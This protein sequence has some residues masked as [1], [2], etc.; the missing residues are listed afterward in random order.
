MK[1]RMTRGGVKKKEEEDEE[2]SRK[3]TRGVGRGRRR[4][5]WGRRRTGKQG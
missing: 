5:K 4:T 3:M 1:R 2:G